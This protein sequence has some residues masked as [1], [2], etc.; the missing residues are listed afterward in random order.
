MMIVIDRNPKEN[1]LLKSL[2]LETQSKKSSQGLAQPTLRKPL[3][4]VL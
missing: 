1:W 3:S 4:E 2:H